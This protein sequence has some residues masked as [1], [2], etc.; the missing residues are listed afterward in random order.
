MNTMG[1]S[2]ATAGAESYIVHGPESHDVPPGT[3]HGSQGACG[4]FFSFFFW[5]IFPFVIVLQR[6]GVFPIRVL[7]QPLVTSLSGI[8]GL[9]I[10]HMAALHILAPA[11]LTPLPPSW[12]SSKSSDW[13][14]STTT[15]WQ[16]VK[17][18]SASNHHFHYPQE[19]QKNLSFLGHRCPDRNILL[20]HSTV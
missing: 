2:L 3:I 13:G 12:A 14:C 6:P 8:I 16:H 11:A 9:E 5:G 10:L 15:K 1:L 4:V 17:E 18:T 19:M 7:C 20:P